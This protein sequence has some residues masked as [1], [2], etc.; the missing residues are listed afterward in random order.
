MSEGF[1]HVRVT[2]AA[3]FFTRRERDR[4]PHLQRLRALSD[5]GVYIAGGPSL[6][7]TTADLFFRVAR[8]GDARRLV[9]EDPYWRAGTWVEYRTRPFTRFVE[10]G[11]RVPI[12]LDGSRPIVIVEAAAVDAAAAG[13]ALGDLQ[14]AERVAF[15]GLLDDRA[16]L[17]VTETA[18]EALA[19]SWFA[20]GVWRAER[21][22]AR[23]FLRV[24]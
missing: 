22:I 10:P 23:S 13:A 21:T 20:D 6:D 2:A 3:D 5:E 12:V 4:D 15:A 16:A 24:F 7:G 1:V 11:R 17:A 8:A 19:R 9:E 14:R 18:D